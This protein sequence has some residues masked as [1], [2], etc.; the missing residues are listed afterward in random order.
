M[1]KIHKHPVHDTDTHFIIDPITRNI[2]NTES[3]KTMLMQYDHNS[4]R[5]SFQIPREVEGHDMTLCN[6]IELHYTNT[7]GSTR[8]QNTDVYEIEDLMLSKDSQSTVVFTWLISGNATFHPGTLAFLITFIC[9]EEG[10]VVYRWN[11][12]ICNTISISAGMNNGEAVIEEYSDVLAQWR[13][14]LFNT[15]YAY[16]G[17]VKNGFEGTEEEWYETIMEWGKTQAIWN[18]KQNKLSWVTEADIDAM[19]DGTYTGVEDEEAEGSYAVDVVGETL[20]IG[21]GVDV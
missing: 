3:K 1:T 5:F 18:V 8:E 19:F 12:G 20:I 15:D 4:E 16:E 10:E 21:S 14:I 17:A 13:D 9:E 7:N 11:T 2:T 6:R